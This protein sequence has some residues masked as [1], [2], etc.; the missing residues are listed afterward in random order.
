M[1]GVHR[2]IQ[3]GR[4]TGTRI[5]RLV[6]QSP[7]RVYPVGVPVI[8]RRATTGAHGPWATKA[9]LSP[10]TLPTLPVTAGKVGRVSFGGRVVACA[11]EKTAVSQFER[12]GPAGFRRRSWP[13]GSLERRSRSKMSFSPAAFPIFR[14]LCTRLIQATR[15]C[16]MNNGRTTAQAAPCCRR[17]LAPLRAES[18]AVP[19]RCRLKAKTPRPT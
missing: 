17:P 13:G 10:P 1:T 16:V 18:R 9:A 11:R 2:G 7:Q 8:A 15:G 19:I 4:F 12:L 14:P 5:R 6:G 3:D